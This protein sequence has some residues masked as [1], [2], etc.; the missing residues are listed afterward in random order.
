MYHLGQGGMDVVRRLRFTRAGVLWAG[1]PYGLF[2]FAK[3][4]FQQAAAGN[5][6]RIE[7]ARNGHL[8]ITVSAGFFEWD[9]SR[10]IEH[11]EILTALGISADDL[12]H[13]LQDRSGVTWYCTKKGIFRQTG[14]S[15][16]HF[17]PDPTGDKNGAIRIYEDA[18]GNIW[19]LTVAALFRASSDSLE[20]VAPDINA[21][22]I[23]SD[24]EGNLWV[25]TNGAGL[26]RFK[27]RTVRTFTKADGLPNNLVMTVLA[28]ADGK[29][30]AGN[31]CGGLSCARKLS[32]S[33]HLR[34]SLM[35]CRKI[36]TVRSLRFSAWPCSEVICA[37]RLPP[38]V[39]TGDTLPKERAAMLRNPPHILVT[40]P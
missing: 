21:R 28:A 13:V 1:T 22:N 36:L 7:E 31:N 25:G 11:P 15:V 26:V 23:I 35:M 39:R 8:L 9:G 3:D 16:K 30:W 19:F 37:P 10:V 34:P 2:Y 29:L 38:G 4:H 12:F 33:V 24:R 32:T 6:Q 27:N 20:S 18:A 17:L 14:G 5:I 40:T